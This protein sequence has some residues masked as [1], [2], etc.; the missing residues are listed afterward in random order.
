MPDRVSTRSANWRL[1]GGGGLLLGGTLWFLTELID[2]LGGAEV[3]VRVLAFAALAIAGFALAFGQTGSNGIVGGSVLGKLGYVAFGIGFALL[4]M[5]PLLALIGVALPTGF[6]TV[7]I[8]LIGLGALV[9]AI[10]TA[11]KRVARGV[12]AW[13]FFVPAALSVIWPLVTV[14]AVSIAGNIVTILLSV[15][16]ALAGGFF[17]FNRR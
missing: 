9:G 11:R 7:G 6:A 17:L 8:V 3:W 2:G 13:I 12:A 15:A 5:A 1:F 14:G 4:A 10:I 16:L